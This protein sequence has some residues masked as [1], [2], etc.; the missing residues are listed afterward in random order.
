[1][2]PLL[3]GPLDPNPAFP[4]SI[5]QLVL[6]PVGI[7]SGTYWKGWQTGAWKLVGDPSP[8]CCRQTP[9]RSKLC[10]VKREATLSVPAPLLA[11]G[12]REEGSPS[13]Q[14]TSRPQVVLNW[15]PAPWV[16]GSDLPQLYKA[17][18]VRH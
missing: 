6:A 17:L 16:A 7:P 2:L 18:V 11:Q 3:P 4:Q 12:V 9:G 15:K 1:M 8:S 14:Y 5:Q 10:P 13:A